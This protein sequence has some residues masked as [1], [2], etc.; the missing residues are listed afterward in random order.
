MGNKILLVGGGGNCRSIIDVLLEEDEYDVIGIVDKT[1]TDMSFLSE[2]V[3]YA[4]SDT[5][6]EELFKDGWDKAFISLGS[7]GDTSIRRHLYSLV[8]K[9]GYIVP[10]IVSKTAVVSERCKLG[11]GV[12][13]SKG[14]VINVCS[15]I[16]N[17]CLINTNSV[18]EHD[19]EVGDFVHVSPGAVLCGGVKIGADSH[20][21]AGSVVKQYLTIGNNTIIGMGSVVTKDLSSDSVYYGNPCKFV[22]NR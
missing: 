17:C 7:V 1:K 2:K 20:I 18:I 8:K 10:N 11:E 14:A 9:V 21:G 12:F 22:K 19:C 15:T 4:G 5:E 13:V 16:G 3:F 6:L